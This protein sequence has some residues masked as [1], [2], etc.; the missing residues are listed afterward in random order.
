MRARQR[1]SFFYGNMPEMLGF[2]AWHA[3]QVH[4]FA[5]KAATMI[6]QPALAPF[7]QPRPAPTARA[8]PAEHA[9]QRG[10]LLDADEGSHSNAD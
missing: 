9:D 1:P 7:P 6:I 5:R 8:L 10:P 4:Q 3:R 2:A